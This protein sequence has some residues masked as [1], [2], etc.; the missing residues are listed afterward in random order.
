MW[1]FPKVSP[2]A[3]RVVGLDVGTAAVRVAD[4]EPGPRPALRAFGHVDL[5]PGA[6]R[7]GEVLDPA[8]V[9]D[10]IRRLWRET[11]LRQHRARVGVASE[12]VLVRTIELPSL[13]DAELAGALQYQAQDYVPFPVDE[14]ILDFHVLERITGVDGEPVTRVLLAAAHRQTVDAL[15]SAVKGAGVGVSGVDL[16]PLALIRGLGATGGE[17]G[18]AEAIVSVEADVTTIVVHE[19]GLPRLVRIVA[20]GGDDVTESSLGRI[21]LPIQSSLDYYLNQTETAPLVRVLL[22]GGG[23]RTAGLAESIASS[24]G[25][26]VEPARPRAT[27][28]VGD[29]GVPEAQL[30]ELDPYL[31]VAVGLALGGPRALG[32]QIDLLP[33]EARREE[34]ARQTT[35]RLALV[36]AVVLVVL[37]GT[38]LF[39]VAGATGQ[40][41][42]LADQRRTNRALQARVDE[43]A[44]PQKVQQDLALARQR[45]GTA[46]AGD[47][48]WPRVLEDLAATLPPTVWLDSFSLQLAGGAGAGTG[49]AA[50]TGTAT[51]AAAPGTGGPMGTASFTAKALDFPSVAA[52]L[53]RLPRLPYYQNL[54]VSS[55]SKT[56]GG[57]RPL[58]SFTSSATV[59]PALRSDRLQRLVEQA[60]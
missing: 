34:A 3:E 57:T 39:Q 50:T 44:G 17:P 41:G 19:A 6:V 59:G 42:R 5:P 36:A 58:V 8:A 35:R 43:L 37:V 29:I 28:D 24:L 26:P 38:S 9:A 16:L 53:D 13:T 52:W 55:V 51:A 45:V 15:L 30:S 56:E 33:P 2:M 32:P 31:P 49:G 40:R 23:S 1:L 21:T 46:L 25:E 14:S 11:G 47:V 20:V 48:S 18:T 10:A 54:S 4:V 12:R 22:T 27:L 7:G 60:L